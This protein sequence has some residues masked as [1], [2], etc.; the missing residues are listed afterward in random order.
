MS[1]YYNTQKLSPIK[2]DAVI[3]LENVALRIWNYILI[4]PVKNK[5]ILRSTQNSFSNY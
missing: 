4:Q 3:I 1:Y 2:H 5:T